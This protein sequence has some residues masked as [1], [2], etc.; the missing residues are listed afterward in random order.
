MTILDSFF[1]L[2]ESDTS[3]LDKGLE[4]SEKK[5]QGL[6]DKLK[7]IDPAATKAGEGLFKVVGQAAGLLGIGLSVGAL[8]A[9]IKSTA[10][11][12]DELGKL[13]SRFRSTVDAVDEFRDAASL[14]GITEE[15]STAA[16]KGLDTAVQ[17]TYLGLGRAKIVFEELGIAVTDAHGKIKPTTAV[18]E[19]LAG[20]LS[21]MEKGTQIRVMERL[22][23]D[24][25]LLKLFNADLVGLQKRMADVDRASGFNLEEAVKRAQEY[26]KA[27]KNLS[28]EVNVL[29]MYMD[30]LS[31]SFKVKAMPYLTE[32][33]TAAAK[34]VRMFVEYLMNHQKFVEGVFVA[35]SSAIMYFLVPA[36]IKG[37]I[38][39]LAMVAPFLLIGAA[40]AA[41]GLAFAL[42]Y[43]DVMAFIDGND[44]L[45]GQILQKWPVIG[46]IAHGIWTALKELWA[47]GMQV[48]DFYAL[49]WNRPQ[50]AFSKFL[51]FV[52]GGL[53]RIL[54]AIPGV[55]Q[56]LDF[57]GFGAGPDGVSEGQQQLASAGSSGLSSQTSS[58]IMNSRTASRSTTVQVGKV[59]V[60]TQ[61]T[62][63]AGIS[64]AIGGSMETQMR[65][66][67]NNFDDGVLA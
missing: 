1:I 58:S 43:E 53:A 56:A 66:A 7:N 59:E 50:E 47:V 13:A 36:A 16:L 2:F 22:G 27:N 28:L 62:D 60:S 20:K 4:H 63:A 17:D 9:G 57:F 49:M 14:L 25:S 11:S 46:T 61:A 32:A 34:Y 44:S 10:A 52:L 64:K 39:V 33:L 38:A 21:K 48:L 19:E 12:Y 55:K 51:D 8:V 30:K 29:R 45:I 35:I 5:S 24:P 37:A 23:L 6:L 15:T 3:K 65:Q 41:V 54:R 31:E 40:V 26:T 42:A 18:M 67:V